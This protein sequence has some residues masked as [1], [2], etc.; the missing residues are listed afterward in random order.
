M[1]EDKAVASRLEGGSPDALGILISVSRATIG[2]AALATQQ[3]AQECRHIGDRQA[4]SLRIRSEPR[5]VDEALRII[6]AWHLVLQTDE[7]CARLGENN[8]QTPLSRI[9]LKPS[10]HCKP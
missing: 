3:R 5:R 9:I 7:L 4:V 1:R 6:A 8:L 10:C 2:S